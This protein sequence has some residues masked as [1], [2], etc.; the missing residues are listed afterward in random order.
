MYIKETTQLAGPFGTMP[1]EH[2]H[3]GKGAK[4]DCA[5]SIANNSKSFANRNKSVIRN[6]LGLYKCF[7]IYLRTFKNIIMDL[8]V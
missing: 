3:P 5:I 1:R 2:R 8:M 6:D 4:L 7:D